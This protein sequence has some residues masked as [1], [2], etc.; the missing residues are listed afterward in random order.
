[1]GEGIRLP[2]N[3]WGTIGE[4]WKPDMP[5]AVAV[6][7]DE[8]QAA[9]MTTGNNNNNNSPQ[10]FIGLCSPVE[11]FCA[12]M[13]ILLTMC[14]VLI[15]EVMGLV[16]YICAF[17]PYWLAKPM[18]PPNFFTGILYSFFMIFYYAFAIADSV[19]LLASVCVA[20]SCA[21][22]CWVTSMLFGGIF[23][24]NHRHQYIRRTCHAIRGSLRASFLNPPRHLFC[25]SPIPADK[26]IKRETEIVSQVAM[27]V[28]DDIP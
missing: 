18:D 11:L 26:E 12:F 2:G 23:V 13:V 16:W 6:P 28:I 14:G 19:C 17:V 24:A 21:V 7:V 1:V 20:E 10:H 27:V 25:S 9:P 5:S 8:E 15:C 22:V 3:P 4:V